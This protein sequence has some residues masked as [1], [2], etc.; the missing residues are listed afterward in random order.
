MP[1]QEI[2][3]VVDGMIQSG[4][5]SRDMRDVYIRDLESGLG[6]HLLRGSD[7]TNKTKELA[8]ARREAEI[9]FQNEKQKIQ[10]ERL[11]LEQWYRKVEGELDAANR[12]REEREALN[13]RLAA[14]E[15]ALKDYSIYDQVN[16]PPAN[17]GSRTTPP[18]N[19]PHNPSYTP[20]NPNA[21]PGSLPYL[22]RDEFNNAVAGW[23]TLQNKLDKI[24]AEHQRLFNEPLQDDLITHFQQTGQDPEEHW[25][26]KYAVENRRAEVQAKNREAEE[27]A[28]EARL[29]Q[30]IMSEIAIDPS[31]MAGNPFQTPK[32]GL[33]PHLEQYTA[34]RALTHSQNHSNDEAAKGNMDFIPPEQRPEIQAAQNRISGANKFY[35]QHFDINGNP[36]S[37]Q[38]RQYAQRYAQT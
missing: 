7:Y 36:T 27:A 12:V 17:N 29:R 24:K 2:E 35:F 37:E 31:K 4:R 1:N 16:L 25:R 8:N 18:V 21:N 22:T 30:K 10:E 23:M 20:P 19:P 11:K 14:A 9:H 13:A 33:T 26:V 6:D 34:S 28:M 15:Q 32:G 3:R 38:G 5:I